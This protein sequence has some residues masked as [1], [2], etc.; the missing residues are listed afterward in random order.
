VTRSPITDRAIGAAG[1]RDAATC[2]IVE[3]VTY[4]TLAAQGAVGLVIAGALL[5]LL[6]RRLYWLLVGAAGFIAGI[7]LAEHLALPQ[8]PLVILAIALVAGLIG[9]VLALWLQAAMVA[10]AGFAIGAACA[11]ALF[12]NPTAPLQWQTVPWLAV[13]VGGVLGAVLVLI[14]FDWALILLSSLAGAGLLVQPLHGD[15]TLV[16]AAFCAAVLVGIAVQATQL[17]TAAPSR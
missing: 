5:L 10:I 13:L 16:S 9:A 15:R 12:A 2:A 3:Q 8:P 4:S 7:R 11:D 1:S 6:G 17:R 14:V